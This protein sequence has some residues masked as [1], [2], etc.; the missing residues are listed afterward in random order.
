MA[1]Y[2]LTHSKKFKCGIAGAG[3]YDWRLY[4]TIYTERYMRTPQENKAGYDATSVIKAAKSLHGHLVILHGS[5]D[6]NV[7]MQN[8]M[9]LLWALQSAGK[10]NFEFMLYPRSRH[11]LARQVSRHSRE[12]QWLRLKKLLDPAGAVAEV[13]AG[14]GDEPADP[15][16]AMRAST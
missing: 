6:D 1:A 5:M 16:N 9:Q 12:F 14:S 15:V 2:A 4:D 3:V 8:A 13:S 7:H 11:G 10:Q